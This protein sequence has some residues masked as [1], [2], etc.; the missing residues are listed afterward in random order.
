MSYMTIFSQRYKDKYGKELESEPLELQ[1]IYKNG[2]VDAIEIFQNQ[3]NLIMQDVK[4]SPTYTIEENEN[5]I[6]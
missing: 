2:Y 3:L 6:I 5:D 4:N 1:H